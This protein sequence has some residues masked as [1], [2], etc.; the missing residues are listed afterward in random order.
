M[1]QYQQ[2]QQSQSRFMNPFR[3][4]DMKPT[5]GS[6]SVPDQYGMLGLLSI[7]K[8]VNPVLTS[9]AL[10]I[11][12]TTLGLNLNSS[13]TLHKKFASPWS[14]EPVRGEPEY[15]VPEC[16]YAQ[17]PPQ[18]K[19]T[20]TMAFM[21]WLCKGITL[22]HA[23]LICESFTNAA[24]LLCT[25]QAGSIVLYLLQVRSCRPPA[26]YYSVMMVLNT[27]ILICCLLVCQKTNYNSLQ[28]MNCK[29][30]SASSSTV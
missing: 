22:C 8:M 27:V 25:I 15:V 3:E 12:L 11:D 10:G 28:Q 7:I 29:F 24:R 6:Q 30:F 20:C 18:L 23:H 13:E 2:F 4:K 17:Q 21:L 16:Y 19:V 14:D 5:Q 9:L 26:I 1:Q